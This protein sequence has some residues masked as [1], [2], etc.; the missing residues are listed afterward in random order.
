MKP[1]SLLFCVLS[2]GVCAEASIVYAAPSQAAQADAPADQKA[3]H[4]ELLTMLELDGTRS[5]MIQE[6]AVGFNLAAGHIEKLPITKAQ[7]EE[8]LGDLKRMVTVERTLD[9]IALQLARD[10]S[11]DDVRA[12]NLLMREP[13][14]QKYNKAF[15]KAYPQLEK[16]I[17]Q[18]TG[19]AWEIME[20][21][22]VRMTQGK[23]Q[24]FAK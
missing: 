16:L 23:V 22:L 21:K 14:Y 15:D 24:N 7:K 12:I 18:Y 4:V 17:L 5:Y 2:L 11:I 13:V 20:R 19:E 10:L 3:L 1:T 9:E 6:L 8:L